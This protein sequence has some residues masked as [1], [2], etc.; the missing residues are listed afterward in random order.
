MKNLILRFQ[1]WFWGIIL[2]TIIWCLIPLLL[3]VLT[4]Y[5]IF[6]NPSKLIDSEINF[7]YKKDK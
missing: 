7:N 1:V 2:M 4:L 3:V 5:C 6:G